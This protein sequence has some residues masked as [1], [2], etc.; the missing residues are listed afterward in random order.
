MT[1]H[2]AYGRPAAV[3]FSQ[4]K[5]TTYAFLTY[6]ECVCAVEIASVYSLNIA[7]LAQRVLIYFFISHL[8]EQ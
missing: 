1:T 8:T 3:R 5:Q 6:A 2:E 7:Y 4:I